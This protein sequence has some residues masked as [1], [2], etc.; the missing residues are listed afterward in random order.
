MRATDWHHSTGPDPWRGAAPGMNGWKTCTGGGWHLTSSIRTATAACG[1]R[2]PG[3]LKK[4]W[5]AGCASCAKALAPAPG[6][7][8]VPSGAHMLPADRIANTRSKRLNRMRRHWTGPLKAGRDYT[9]W[10]LRRIMKWWQLS[11][12]WP[13]RSV[14]QTETHSLGLFGLLRTQVVAGIWVAPVRPTSRAR[15]GC[16]GPGISA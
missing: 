12:R 10:H 14:D 11:R 15:S 16:A 8:P 5:P 7:A 9:G 1:A 6:G 13:C 2:A 3:W 4:L